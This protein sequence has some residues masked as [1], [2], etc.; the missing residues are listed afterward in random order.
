MRLDFGRRNET[1]RTSDD[2]GRCGWNQRA[3]SVW[4]G[5]RRSSTR[6]HE[7]VG[8]L[9]ATLRGG[10]SPAGDEIDVS[11]ILKR[12]GEAFT[13][14]QEC[15]NKAAFAK[16]C[17]LL[18]DL[19]GQVA[20]KKFGNVTV[21]TCDVTCDADKLRACTEDTIKV[22]LKLTVEAEVTGLPDPKV[23]IGPVTFTFTFADFDAF[24]NSIKLKNIAKKVL[25]DAKEDLKKAFD[26]FLDELTKD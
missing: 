22:T 18:K 1:I 21:N 4:T 3:A 24:A 12:L 17:E 2:C 9:E 14:V 7:S 15:K 10:D 26:K 20:G 8:S 23:P 25:K 11:R 19:C 16:L 6:L 13:L 5:W